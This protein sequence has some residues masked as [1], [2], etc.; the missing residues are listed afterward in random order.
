MGTM[1]TG[2]F[3][4][5]VLNPSDHFAQA[6]GG[7]SDTSGLA[8]SKCSLTRRNELLYLGRTWQHF[9]RTTMRP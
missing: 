1:D 7:P 2:L 3:D 4:P 9:M 8:T 5:N 6:S